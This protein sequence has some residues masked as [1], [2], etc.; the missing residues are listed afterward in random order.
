MEQ[1][2]LDEQIKEVEAQIQRNIGMLDLLRALREKG[3][4]VTLPQQAEP[5]PAQDAASV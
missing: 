3:A 1:M 5:K 4:V 2:N